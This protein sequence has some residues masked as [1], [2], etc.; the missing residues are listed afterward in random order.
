MKYMV[1][2]SLPSATYRGAVARFLQNGGAVPA[3][4]KMISRYH[5][6][7]GRGVAIVETTDAK[8]LFTWF[9]EWNEFL[10][11]ETTPVVE[12]ADCAAVLGALFK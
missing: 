12:D 8:A 7:N 9:A 10:S 1:S 2:W 6:M 11:I 5:G 3:G 4:V